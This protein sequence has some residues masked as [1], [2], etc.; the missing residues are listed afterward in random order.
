MPIRI[1]TEENLVQATYEEIIKRAGGKEVF[2]SL[3]TD[4]IKQINEFLQIAGYPDSVK[5]NE[6]ILCHALLDYLADIHRLK[7]FHQIK[8]TRTEKDTAYIAYWIVRRK[9]IQFTQYT[10]EEK[11]IFA[12]ERFACYLILTEGM[13]DGIDRELGEKEIKQYDD[14][15]DFLLYYFKY[16]QINPQTIELL[17]NTFRVGR[18]FPLPQQ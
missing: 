15:L 14:Y 2:E 7:D 10:E 11:D 16:R 17:I 1:F 18:M 3:I 12:N 5:C 6:R 8:N 4:V 9:P 13:S